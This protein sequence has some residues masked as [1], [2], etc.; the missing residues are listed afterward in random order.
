MQTIDYNNFGKSIKQLRLEETEAY[1]QE[2]INQGMEEI[3][4]TELLGILESLNYKIDKSMCNR[5]YNNY[6]RLSYSA[7][8]LSYKDLKSKQSFA[9]FEQS[10]TN[11]D[12]L[13]QLQKVRQR[14]FVYKNGEIWDL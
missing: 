6:N 9:H 4:E 7:Y 14:T 13:A 10:F 3:T 1:R 12:N 2:L 8:S 5:Y 11:A